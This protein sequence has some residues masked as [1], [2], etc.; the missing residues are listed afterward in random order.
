LPAPP[1]SPRTRDC[2]E[3]DAAVVETRGVGLPLV[4]Q[5]VGEPAFTVEVVLDS[6]P[7][8]EGRATT[9]SWWSPSSSCACWTCLT[10]RLP[11]CPTPG[12]RPRRRSVAVWRP[13]G[14]HGTAGHAHRPVQAGRPPAHRLQDERRR[15]T[16][17]QPSGS[18]PSRCSQPGVGPAWLTD[19][20][21]GSPGALFLP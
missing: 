13:C 16:D 14:P 5:A 15:F 1:G 19:V 4:Q 6:D 11:A 20:D 10:S 17:P 12:R 18:T 3:R 9:A 21:P 2:A 8:S 7:R